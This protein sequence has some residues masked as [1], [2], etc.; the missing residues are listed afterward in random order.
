MLFGVYTLF[1]INLFLYCWCQNLNYCGQN[2]FNKLKKKA[3]CCLLL[4]ISVVLSELRM[5]HLVFEYQECDKRCKICAFIL[6]KQTKLYRK[7]FS[8]VLRCSPSSMGCGVQPDGILEQEE[9]AAVARG[10]KRGADFQYLQED[11]K[12]LNWR[13]DPETLRRGRGEVWRVQAE[14][15]HAYSHL[16]RPQGSCVL[17]SAHEPGTAKRVL[18]S[19][20]LRLHGVT[21]HNWRS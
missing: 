14:E 5:R 4:R 2:L 9:E 17:P 12:Q 20:S 13:F 1:L 15:R 7:P 16:H 19:G 3:N 11:G 6:K 8:R 21:N 10:T 18:S